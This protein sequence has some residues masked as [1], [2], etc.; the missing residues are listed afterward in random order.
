MDI[1]LSTLKKANDFILDCGS[2]RSPK[3]FGIRVM[4]KI[5]AL[6]P[7]DQARLYF[8]DDNGVVFDEYLLGIDRH[9][10]KLYHDYYSHVDNGAFSM[11]KKANEFRRRYPSVEECLYD[12]KMFMNYE[13]FYKGYVRPHKI[14]YCFGLGLRDLDNTLR[15]NISLERL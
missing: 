9:A 1:S 3:E 10:S 13:E 11:A 7:F 14:K 2:Y 12:W 4:D 6:I 8:L 15:C 5:G